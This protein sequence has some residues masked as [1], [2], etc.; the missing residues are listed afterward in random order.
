MV[1]HV[2]HE[3]SVTTNKTDL[4][5][6]TYEDILSKKYDVNSVEFK[7]TLQELNEQL[8]QLA[9]KTTKTKDEHEEI[10]NIEDTIL[11]LQESI[12]AKDALAKYERH[13]KER[14]IE[15]NQLIDELKG[16]E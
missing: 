12:E 15:L 13:L 5:A 8:Q 11:R 7:Y 1:G 3:I 14:E 4:W 10:A 6:W 9:S 16:E 2:W